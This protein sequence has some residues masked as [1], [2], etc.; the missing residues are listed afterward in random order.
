VARE[1]GEVGRD[2]HGG[3]AIDSEKEGERG[4]GLLADYTP[5]NHKFHINT[6]EF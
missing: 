5:P 2:T 1:K 6:V 3:T 4:G